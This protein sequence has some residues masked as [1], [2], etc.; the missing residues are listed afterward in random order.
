MFGETASFKKRE[1]IKKARNRS[2]VMKK[3]IARDNSIRKLNLGK[4][5]V[6]RRLI[7]LGVLTESFGT[8]LGK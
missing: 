5:L 1:K 6:R 4:R 2:Q 8:D 7:V 3:L